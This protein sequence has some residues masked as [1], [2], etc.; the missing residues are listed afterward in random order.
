MLNINEFKSSLHKYDVSRPSLFQVTIGTAPCFNDELSGV[1]QG[2]RDGNGSLTQLYCRSAGI[3]SRSIATADVRRYGIG[4]NIKMPYFGSQ[5]DVTLT[6]MNDAHNR[7]YSFFNAWVNYIYP[8]SVRPDDSPSP[9]DGRRYN[10]RFK[11]KYTTDITIAAYGPDKGTSSGLSSLVTGAAQSVLSIA[12]TALKVPFIGSLLN[13]SRSLD[14]KLF[15]TMEYTIHKAFP[16]SISGLQYSSDNSNSFHEFSVT[17][18][19]QDYSGQTNI[20]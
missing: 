17:F 7:V 15:K 12:T 11:D 4:P 1:L 10:L 3:P 19:F 2:V 9:G 8:T 5:E 20:R 13:G 6:F 16:T 18:S 14:G